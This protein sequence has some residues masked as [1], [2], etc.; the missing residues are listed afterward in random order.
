MDVVQSYDIF[1]GDSHGHT[2][3]IVRVSQQ[4]LENSFGKEHKQL[5]IL[6]KILQ[7]GSISQYHGTKVMKEHGANVTREHTVEVR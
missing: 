3:Q 2:G 5:E 1:T 4:M 6:Q 7:E